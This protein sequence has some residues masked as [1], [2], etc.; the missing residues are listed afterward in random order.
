[1]TGKVIRLRGIKSYRHPKS[2]IV[3]HYHRP[4]GM[5]LKAP[6]GSA[7]FVQE[8]RALEERQKL[9]EAQK[10]IPGTLG[11]AI[12]KWRATPEWSNL[13]PK[14]RVSYERAIAVLQPLEDMPLVQITRPFILDLRTKIFAKRGRWMS[15][16]GV[17]VLRLILAFS[18][19]RGWLGTNPL[20][21]RVKKVR[22]AVLLL[23]NGVS[24][25]IVDVAAGR[26]S[27]VPAQ[28]AR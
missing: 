18:V 7:E 4:T 24:G 11:L 5:R 15:N 21:E 3:Y 14:T 2:G 26:T 28:A 27:G 25:G 10:A 17:T 16:Y 6:Y 20:A 9:K 23:P 22:K 8:V 19:D 1:M 13:K 12:G